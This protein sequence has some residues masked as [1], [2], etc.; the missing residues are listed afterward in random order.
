[1]KRQHQSQLRELAREYNQ[2]EDEI[3]RLVQDMAPANPGGAGQQMLLGPAGIKRLVNILEQE[4]KYRQQARAKKTVEKR[5]EVGAPGQRW[6]VD[7]VVGRRPHYPPTYPGSRP[8]IPVLERAARRRFRPRRRIR[9]RRPLRSRRAGSGRWSGPSQQSIDRANFFEQ[10]PPLSAAPAGFDY[11]QQMGT[12]LEG[13]EPFGSYPPGHP[14]E[15]PSSWYEKGYVAVPGYEHLMQELTARQVGDDRLEPMVKGSEVRIGGSSGSEAGV[16]YR[17]HDEVEMEE[18]SKISE[19]EDNI[20]MESSPGSEEAVDWQ[21][22]KSV[23]DV[24]PIRPSTESGFAPEKSKPQIIT[25]TESKQLLFAED[26]ISSE[27]MVEFPPEAEFQSVVVGPEVEITMVPDYTS[28]PWPL[29]EWSR[30]TGESWQPEPAAPG[31]DEA[32][33]VPTDPGEKEEAAD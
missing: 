24:E 12:V 10:V 4:K 8:R 26:E 6:E 13:G 7:P 20:N 33:P 14:S 1:M 19:W 22:Q 9:F 30:L 31:H 21:E 23:S 25:A 2:S 32:A 29:A 28:L 3:A 16:K 18:E 15:F 17:L 5:N 11:G 27:T